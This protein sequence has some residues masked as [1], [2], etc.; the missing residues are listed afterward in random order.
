MQDTAEWV[1]VT[2]IVTAAGASMMGVSA[3]IWQTLGTEAAD[4]ILHGVD[5]T[6]CAER[7]G[8]GAPSEWSCTLYIVAHHRF[9]RWGPPAVSP[10]CPW[11]PCH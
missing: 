6:G 2:A 8:R 3:G 7:L 9:C 11:I 1:F 4:Q 5:D 10:P